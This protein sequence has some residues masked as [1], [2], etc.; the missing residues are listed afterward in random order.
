MEKHDGNLLRR[1]LIVLAM[2]TAIAVVAI[3]SRRTGLQNTMEVYFVESALL[4]VP[5]L[6]YAGMVRPVLRPLPAGADPLS[7]ALEALLAGPLA[8]ETNRFASAIPAGT[9]LRGIVRRSGV[10]F[11]DFDRRL[12]AY[13]GGSANA[14]CIRAQIER[15]VGAV[16]GV[17]RVEILVDG[18]SVE[19]LEP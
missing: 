16:P 9:R 13:G 12:R 19:I 7:N 3:L 4:D 1:G 14:A 17:R 6:D 15:T 8:G 2:L 10:V 18:A 5:E 11:V